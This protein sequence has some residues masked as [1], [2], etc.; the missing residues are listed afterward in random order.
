M[1][2]RD[3]AGRWTKS[4]RRARL[5]INTARRIVDDVARQLATLRHA[6]AGLTFD[7]A[8]WLNARGWRVELG[9]QDVA[10]TWVL[11]PELVLPALELS[12]AWELSQGVSTHPAARSSAS[13]ALGAGRAISAPSD[14]AAS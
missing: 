14:A 8:R 10:G 6:N 9:S 11:F 7:D 2:A 4:S 13:D 3:Q 5:R 1:A 12:Q